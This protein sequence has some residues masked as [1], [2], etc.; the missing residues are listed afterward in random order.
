L[1]IIIITGGIFQGKSTLALRLAASNHYSG[2]ISTDLIRNTLK[3]IYPEKK[4]FFTST[5]DWSVE[6]NLLELVDISNVLISLINIYENRGEK[7]IIEGMHLSD[8]IFDWLKSKKYYKFVLNNTISFEKRIFYKQITK[9]RYKLFD[10]SAFLDISKE[11]IKKSRYY[12]HQDFFENI[13]KR[14]LSKSIESGFIKIEF[15]SM[16]QAY[17]KISENLEKHPFPD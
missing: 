4:Y 14:L 17:R 9:K 8:Q 2:V 12:E 15:S 11:N 13:H 3:T 6:N 7:I 10:G 5:T 16:E 1:S